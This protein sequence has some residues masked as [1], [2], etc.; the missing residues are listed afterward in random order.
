MARTERQYNPAQPSGW[1]LGRPFSVSCF[2]SF[3]LVIPLVRHPSSSFLSVCPF[4]Y[5]CLNIPS[6]FF[7][8]PARAL[9]GFHACTVLLLPVGS[10][11]PRPRQSVRDREESHSGDPSAIKLPLCMVLPCDDD[12]DLRFELGSL[13]MLRGALYW[14]SYISQSPFSLPGLVL[15]NHS[16]Q[17]LKPCICFNLGELLKRLRIF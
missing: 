11:T 13:C 2:R 6:R 15:P 14:I 17:Q 16:L 9:L 10:A 12:D 3:P 1:S 4:L 8:F 7:L 5:F